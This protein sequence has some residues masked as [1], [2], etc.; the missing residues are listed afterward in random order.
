MASVLSRLIVCRFDSAHSLAPGNGCG[1]MTTPLPPPDA[2]G[3]PL[4]SRVDAKSPPI[5]GGGKGVVRARLPKAYLAI[6]PPVR[7][8]KSGAGGLW[9]R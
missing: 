2:G 3:E 5:L 1:T 8:R 7:R 4:P 9:S 6:H